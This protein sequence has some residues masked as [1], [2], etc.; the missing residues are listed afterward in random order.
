MREF[1]FMQ[2]LFEEGIP[3]PRPIDTNRH[4]I[5]MSLINGDPL[6]HVKKIYEG[7]SVKEIFT[8]SLDLVKKFASCGLIHG[9]FNEFNLLVS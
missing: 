5:V 6:C 1:T 9:D 8:K 7:C 4:A 2:I 3:T